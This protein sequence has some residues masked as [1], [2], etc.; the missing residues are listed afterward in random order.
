MAAAEEPELEAGEDLP[1]SQEFFTSKRAAAV[2]KHAILSGYLVP[3]ASKTG[4]MS[5]GN[6]V[7]I[8]DGYAGAGR[9]DDGQPGSPSLIATAARS[10][11]GRSVEC[12][13]IERDRPTYERLRQVLTEEDAGGSVSWRAIH[14]TVEEHLQD[15]LNRA[16]GV[17]LLLFLDPFG[18]GLPSSVIVDIFNGRP[19]DQYAPATEVLF[20]FD[21]GAIRR[22][23][24]VLHRQADY[25]A[26]DKTLESLDQAAGG[27]WWRDE[28]DPSLSNQQYTEWFIDRLLE[29]L[30][31]Q[32][33]CAG[34]SAEVKQR[35][36][37]QPVY[38]LLFL[39]RHRDGMQ[40]F[41]E[42]LSLA[43]E[44]WRRALHDADIAAEAACGQATLLDREDMWK[45]EEKQLAEQW[46]EQIEANLRTLIAEH[47]RFSIGSQLEA[48]LAGVAGKART[49]H[50]REALKRLRVDGVIT[51]DSK[52]DLWSKVVVRAPAA[53]QP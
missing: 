43:Q 28:D 24:G 1:G 48:V 11:K 6:R 36:N 23:R 31:K 41:G 37:L 42:A 22:I 16:S 10:L 53:P 12:L 25:P 52:G 18:L 7:V 29:R 49:K 51:S 30:C 14:G 38:Y 9:Y 3:F 26:R 45:L 13:F 19:V 2:L 50:L 17:P 27:T 44:K 47:A 39:T 5:T 46:H 34:W 40:V 20:R 33:G 15:L 35:E 21:A 8:V 4:S 32:T